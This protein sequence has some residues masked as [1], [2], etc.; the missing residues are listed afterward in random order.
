VAAS[1]PGP[2]RQI[3]HI[4]A[5]TSDSTT[6]LQKSP[7]A[8]PKYHPSSPPASPPLSPPARVGGR[9]LPPTRVH[10]LAQRLQLCQAP[11]IATV[12]CL[13]LHRR[14][15][16]HAT[17]HR[18]TPSWGVASQSPIGTGFVDHR[19][20]AALPAGPTQHSTTH[21]RPAH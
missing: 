1:R 12:R 2:G 11:Y 10:S 15:R 5:Q 18:S 20:V 8:S 4:T 13:E 6:V 9:D 7:R 19:A 17:S 16:S 14:P 21:S 3:A